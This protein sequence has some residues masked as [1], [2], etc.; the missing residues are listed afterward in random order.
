[1]AHD[2]RHETGLDAGSQARPIVITLALV[3][4]Y[5]GLEVIGGV[6]S[7]SRGTSLRQTGAGRAPSV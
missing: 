7:G 3:V 5:M 6:P 4:L 2:Y 1:M